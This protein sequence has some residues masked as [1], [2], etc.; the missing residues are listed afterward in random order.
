MLLGIE[1]LAGQTTMSK[2]VAKLSKREVFGNVEDSEWKDALCKYLI[3]DMFNC[4]GGETL[5]DCQ[6]DCLNGKLTH[7]LTNNCC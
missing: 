7:G 3:V 1:I 4:S 6:K 2:E 5:N